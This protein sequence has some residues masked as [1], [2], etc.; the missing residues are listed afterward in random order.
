MPN[1]SQTRDFKIRRLVAVAMFLLEDGVS[2]HLLFGKL[3]RTSFRFW[4]GLRE[5]TR[6]SYIVSA[7]R[8]VLSLSP[9]DSDLLTEAVSPQE[10]P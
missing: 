2:P 5:G 6:R 8:V 7:I 1:P 9:V 3:D 10:A 4:P